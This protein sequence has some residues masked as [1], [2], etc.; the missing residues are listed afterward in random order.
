MK[1]IAY[2]TLFVGILLQFYF[3]SQMPEQVAIHFDANSAP[4][5]WTSNT[6]TL[7][8]AISCYLFLTLIFAGCAKMFSCMSVEKMN[9]PNKEYWIQAGRSAEVGNI[10]DNWFSKLIISSNVFL[11]IIFY[12]LMKANQL[13]Q[14]VIDLRSL[15][16]LIGCYAVW[17]TWLCVELIF[18]FQKPKSA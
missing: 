18:K 10:Y 2:L 11:M 13:S 1:K 17:T 8:I 12:M 7:I 16:I 3:S 9:I 4:D 5:I 14:P 15:Y 6:S